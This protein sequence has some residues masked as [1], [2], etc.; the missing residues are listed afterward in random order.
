MS[1]DQ[2]ARRIDAATSASDFDLREVRRS[3]HAIY[4]GVDVN[5]IEQLRPLLTLF[6]QQL[7]DVN[8]TTL[9]RKDPSLKHKVL[10]LLDEFDILGNMPSLA[11]AFPF[12]RAYN[13]QLFPIMQT[14]SQLRDPK[15][16]YGPEAA[17]TIRDNCAAEVVFGMRNLKEA[18]ELSE[19]I[20]NN[21]VVSQ[22]RSG[23]R[24]FRMLNPNKVNTSESDA[25]RALLLPQEIMRLSKDEAIITAAGMYATKAKRIKWYEEKPFKDLGAYPVPDVPEIEVKIRLDTTGA[26]PAGEAE[27][28]EPQG[29]QAPPPPTS[30]IEDPAGAVD[31]N[32]ELV[33]EEE[34]LE[35][36]MMPHRANGLLAA[37]HGQEVDLSQCGL[38]DCK[39]AVDDLISKIPNEAERIAAE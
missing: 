2:G 39:A 27:G 4:V 21:T 10:V 20:G 1:S 7:I 31:V 36:P 29:P 13:I 18:R 9:P 24:L 5:Q 28:D 30:L 37:I 14:H 35:P 11:N 26:P 3:L 6:F 16:S 32:D 23:P 8:V 25:K 19:E 38:D 33:T 12:V 34:A 22:S 17:Q 15:K